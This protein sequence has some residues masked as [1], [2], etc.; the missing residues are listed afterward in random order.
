MNTRFGIALIVCL[1]AVWVAPIGAN[2]APGDFDSTFGSGFGKVLTPMGSAD[3]QAS[4]VVMQPDGKLVVGGVC[5]GTSYRFCVVRYHPDG[6]IDT[7]FGISGKVLTVVPD[8]FASFGGLV[9]Q[10]DGK[11][12]V[13][14]D[15]Y[16][17]ATTSSQF[18]AAR[19]LSN[20]TLDPSFNGD[21]IMV[22]SIS[23]GT[24]IN[25]RKVLLQPGGE[26][27]L[28]ATCGVSSTQFYFCMM[29][30]TP[31]GAFDNTFAG[32]GIVITQIYSRDYLADAT[33]QTDGKLVLAGRCQL[34]TNGPYH[35]CAARY[36]ANGQIDNSFST[37]GV[38]AN[39]VGNGLGDDDVRS[40]MAQRDG[41]IILGGR[42]RLNTGSQHQFC[43][44]RYLADGTVDTSIGS[45][46]LIF[47]MGTVSSTVTNLLLQADGKVV[48]LGSCTSGVSPNTTNDMCMARMHADGQ[49]DWSFGSNGKRIASLV[50]GDDSPQGGLMQPDGKIV[51]VGNCDGAS[52]DDFC[53]ARFEGG[54]FTAQACS[55]D[56]DGDNRV[57]AT[58]DSLIH[59]RIALGIR[60]AAVISGIGFPANATRTTWNNIRDFLVTQCAMDIAP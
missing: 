46:G 56:I 47:N 57:T 6:S 32:G 5:Y 2:A 22:S 16:F 10:P 60:G 48:M 52:N 21:G 7:S 11:I 31:D 40:V 30:L 13:G 34:G 43:I 27:I 36:L 19:Y 39:P 54:P 17:Q 12:V 58:V 4:S 37:D 55:M 15:C 18:C 3:D 59:A 53:I 25:V 51:A 49:L 14:G 8:A 24:S 23:G 9:L 44:L 42:C 50:S 41:R 20:G 35:F 26:I 29:R 45:I 38:V 28:A 33:T 1:L